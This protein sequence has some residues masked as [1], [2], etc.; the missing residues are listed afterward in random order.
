MRFTKNRQMKKWTLIL[1]ILGTACDPIDFRLKLENQTTDTLFYVISQT[2]ELK[3]KDLFYVEPSGD[4]IL[5]PQY[6][7]LDPKKITKVPSMYGIGTNT[8][9]RGI[10]KHCEDSTLTILIYDKE[11]WTTKDLKKIDWRNPKKVIRTKT[12]QLNDN[13]WLIKLD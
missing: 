11:R 12:T 7:T 13:D 5:S 10:N 2:K 4:T 6:G 3:D 8:W 1:L 9:E